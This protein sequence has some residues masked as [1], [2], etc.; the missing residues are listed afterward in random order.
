MFKWPEPNTSFWKDK[1]TQ[2]HKRDTD[3]LNKLIKQWR[4]AI[5]CE[6]ALKGKTRLTPEAMTEQLTAWITSS[7]SFTEIQGENVL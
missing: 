5:I 4:V 2:N 1:F 6:C 7:R 3:I